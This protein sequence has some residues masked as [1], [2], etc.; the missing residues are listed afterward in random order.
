MIFGTISRREY[1]EHHDP[2]R[3]VAEGRKSPRSTVV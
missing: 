1:L 2:D 3:W